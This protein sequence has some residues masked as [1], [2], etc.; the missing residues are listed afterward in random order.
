MTGPGLEQ[1]LAAAK[2]GECP[3]CGDPVKV[4]GKKPLLTCGDEVCW[5]AYNRGY[6]RDLRRHQRRI[7]EE[8]AER[9]RSEKQAVP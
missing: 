1:M 9:R 7:L 3:F 2:P 6:Q 4:R 5:K 8:Y